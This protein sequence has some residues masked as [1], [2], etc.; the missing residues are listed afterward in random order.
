MQRKLF[1]VLLFLAMGSCAT[2][3]KIRGQF[4]EHPLAVVQGA[5][6]ASEAFISILSS[7]SDGDLKYF[8]SEVGKKKKAE[9]VQSYFKKRSPNKK[10]L[11]EKIHI[12]N[13]RPLQLYKL[14]VKSHG[15]VIDER[16]FK[17]LD[18][19][20]TDVRIGVASCMDDHILSAG[21]MW[22]S[23]LNKFLDVNF[24]IGDNVYADRLDSGVARVA[25][26]EQLWLRYTQTW[27]RL[28][29]YHSSSLSPTYYLWDDHDYG[30]NDGGAD[31]KYKK[32]S[33]EIFSA[34][35][36]NEN[37][38]GTY[39]KTFGVGS[40][41]EAFGQKFFFVDA[42]SFRQ[43]KKGVHWGSDQK[44]IIFEELKNS[45]AQIN[46]LI[47]G[48][49]FFGAYHPYE[50]FERDNPKEFKKILD[51]IRKLSKKVVFVSGDRHLTEIMKI[52]G[53]VLG[54]ETFEITSSG[55]HVKVYPGA[56]EKAPNPRGLVG[57]AGVYN[58]SVIELN[59]SFNKKKSRK[60]KFKLTSYGSKDWTHY[61]K[62][63]SL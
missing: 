45:K 52:E 12:E 47:Q 7:A 21:E 53:S 20:R 2:R 24:F 27:D 49:Q 6:S 54:Y 22:K 18:P 63:L 1:T 33:S 28:Y 57:K 11:V 61:T 5:T 58:Y 48:D 44:N 29:F 39:K 13:L 35:H 36:P 4:N 43:N 46:W 60:T 25:D 30:D 59:N 42:R 32:E 3:E 9:L 15:K 31:Y 51:K 50:S 10:R 34:F 40:I 16:Q 14:T 26:P 55:I 23:Y 37:I 41:L 38:E 62:E 17:S 19:L 56:L 8:I